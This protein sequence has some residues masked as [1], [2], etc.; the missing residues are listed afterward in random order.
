M[1]EPILDLTV[2]DGKYRI[3]QLASG[4]AEIL[5]YGRTCLTVSGTP[6]S[7]AILAMAYEL[8]ELRQRVSEWPADAIFQLGATVQK[9]GRAFWRGKI[10][11]WYRTE[12]TAL[13]FA[14]ESMFEPGSVQIYPQTA[15][16]PWNAD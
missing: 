4:G 13:G 15:L 11:G 10:V 1:S 7:N 6:G 5:R 2:D 14:V 9:K 12:L 8:D 16:E 3:I